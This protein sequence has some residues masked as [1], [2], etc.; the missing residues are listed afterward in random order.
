NYTLP[1]SVLTKIL[2]LLD[3]EYIAVYFERITKTRTGKGTYTAHVKGWT[4]EETKILN[5][6]PGIEELTVIPGAPIP[7]P[8]DTHWK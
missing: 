5:K 6:I 3:K 8:Q 1:S 2:Q 7:T 4:D